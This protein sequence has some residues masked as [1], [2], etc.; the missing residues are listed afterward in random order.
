MYLSAP[1]SLLLGLYI[2]WYAFMFGL[3][4]GLP[5][6]FGYVGGRLKR[7]IVGLP[8]AFMPLI[9][10]LVIGGVFGGFGLLNSMVN[11][12][13]VYFI[14]AFFGYIIGFL[15]KIIRLLWKPIPTEGE[16]S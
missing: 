7:H 10:A 8:F 13:V 3:Y 1:V 9:L 5:F 16:S 2:H 4:F 15:W 11:F 12:A 14:V 6:F